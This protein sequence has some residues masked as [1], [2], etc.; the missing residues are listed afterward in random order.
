MNAAP[1]IRVGIG[2]WT[3]EPWRGSF[4][5]PGLPQARELAHASRAL[6]TIE[7]NGTF[8]GLPTP[9]SCAR[10]RA[11]TPEGFVFSL[12]A[13]RYATHRRVLAEAGE[14]I[15]RFAASG[16]AELGDK[17]GPIVWQLPPTKAFDAADLDA[18]LGLLPR[19][20][21]GVPLRH[22]LEPRHESFR[23]PAYLALARRHAVATVFVDAPDLP[24]L[25]DVTGPFVYVR[26][27]RTRPDLTAGV[28]AQALDALAACAAA[29]H[30]GDEPA[31]APRVEPPPPATGLRDVFLLFIGAAKEKSPAAAA[32]L[33]ARLV[34]AGL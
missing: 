2:G 28:P 33:T 20:A 4:Y 19:S 5:P 17:L 27:K 1:A 32:A 13:P 24:G 9:A 29:W 25:A 30:R 12:K 16:I 31:A 21:G 18:F 11:D 10:W 26:V 8:Y 34:S 14:T 7:V 15:E 3:Y 23:T 22:A 6:R